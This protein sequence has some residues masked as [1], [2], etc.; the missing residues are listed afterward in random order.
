[1]I[2]IL[3]KSSGDRSI[4]LSDEGDLMRWVVNVEIRGIKQQQA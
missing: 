2:H 4:R 1:M 3:N